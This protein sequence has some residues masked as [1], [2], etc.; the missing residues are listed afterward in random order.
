MIIF[1]DTD[2]VRYPTLALYQLLWD[3][4]THDMR[5]LISRQ[6]GETGVNSIDISQIEQYVDGIF[7]LIFEFTRCADKDREEKIESKGIY[8]RPTRL[9]PVQPNFTT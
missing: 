8:P 1:S 7:A 4:T 2:L 3:N 5:E 6:F 9:F